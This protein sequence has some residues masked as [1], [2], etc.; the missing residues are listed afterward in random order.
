MRRVKAWQMRLSDHR[1]TVPR[2]DHFDQEACVVIM[3][4]AGPEDQTLI[5]L[6]PFSPH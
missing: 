3:E 6:E 2:I 4:D 1:V 5:Q